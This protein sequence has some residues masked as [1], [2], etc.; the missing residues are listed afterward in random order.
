MFIV[1]VVST[2]ISNVHNQNKIHRARLSYCVDHC[3]KKLAWLIIQAVCFLLSPKQPFCL[4]SIV[5]VGFHSILFIYEDI[6]FIWNYLRQRMHSDALNL[7][8]TL[9]LQGSL[10]KRPFSYIDGKNWI[11][12]KLI[13]DDQKYM[14]QWCFI[15]IWNNNK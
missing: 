2:Q 4:K 8:S 6:Y 9:W 7:C 1:S 5:V 14:S 15:V 13:D 11:E 3:L 10:Q 12:K